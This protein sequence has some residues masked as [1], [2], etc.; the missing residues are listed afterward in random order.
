MP[1]RPN[2]IFIMPDQLRADFLSCYDASFID[3]PNI[4][5]IADRGVIYGS[6]YSAH[7]V[8][9]PAR[10]SLMTG[11][12][13]I[14]NGVLDNGQFLRTDYKDC[15]I[16]TW[17]DI[18]SANGYYTIATG[19][20]HFYPWEVRL[21]FQRKIVAEDKI[22]INVEDDYHHFLAAHGYEKTLGYNKPE[23]HEN[24]MAFISDIPW[25]YSVD[26]F[27]GQESA[28]WIT[29]Y[30]GDEPFA[31]MVGFPGPH[32][33]YDP[34]P[35]YADRFSPDDMP[36]P[37][38]EIPKDTALLRGKGKRPGRRSWYA[39]KNPGRP[40]REHYML[41]RAYYA[42]LVKQIDHEVGCILDALREK[43]ILDNT[44]VIFSSDHGDYL[45][46]HN[47]GGKNSYF[48]GACKVPLLVHYPSAEESAICHDLATL[49]DVTAT[50][51]HFAGCQIPGYMDSIPLPALGIPV[52]KPRERVVGMLTRG[53]MLYDGEWKLVK[54]AGGGSLLFNLRED[55]Q[56]QRN[57]ARDANS[58]GI[59]HR[60]DAELNEAIMSSVNLSHFEKR[61]Y[62]HTLSGSKDFGRVG[63]PRPYPRRYQ[64]L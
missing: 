13:A 25:E 24:F 27:V 42:A 16:S 8:C 56:E 32:P 18:L 37:V 29:E 10:V 53:W 33:P 43:G 57:L 3:T 61:V 40:T 19:K 46:D 2:I 31:M 63:W 7:P 4:D 20:M 60:M 51:L 1:D 59:Y 44:I 11:M 38:P 36:D 17:P 52:E 15:G 64:D 54:Y 12:D 22:W 58:G 47:L 55:P 41:H 28:R 30:E 49:A 48:E 26:H 34:S 50:I 21:G 45:G 23:Y 62:T 39:F 5:S 14:K 6:A 35:E 9:V